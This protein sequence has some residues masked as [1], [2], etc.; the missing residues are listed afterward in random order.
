[1]ATGIEIQIYDY[2][3]VRDGKIY[4]LLENGDR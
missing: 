1:M 4:Q 2:F 3:V